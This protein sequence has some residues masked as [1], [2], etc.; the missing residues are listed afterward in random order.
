[1]KR[2]LTGGGG[3]QR[4]RTWRVKTEKEGAQRRTERKKERKRIMDL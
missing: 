4:Q 1:M 3:G 2:R